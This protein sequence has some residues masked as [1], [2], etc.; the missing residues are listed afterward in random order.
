M[1]LPS[2]QRLTQINWY[3]FEIEYNYANKERFDVLVDE[4][5]KSKGFRIIEVDAS[6]KLYV[7]GKLSMR[8]LFGFLVHHYK[9]RV[10]TTTNATDTVCLNIALAPNFIGEAFGS[11]FGMRKTKRDFY[12][13]VESLKDI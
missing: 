13:L 1:Q 7:K 8:Y 2:Y 12:K 4:F 11:P 9:I 6:S 10:K 3:S 5:V